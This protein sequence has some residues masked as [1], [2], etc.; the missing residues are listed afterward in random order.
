MGIC[1]GALDVRLVQNMKEGA[2]GWKGGNKVP[3]EEGV[4]G[5]TS[6]DTQYQRSLP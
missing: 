3:P 1:V 4:F 2:R 5:S 6:Y